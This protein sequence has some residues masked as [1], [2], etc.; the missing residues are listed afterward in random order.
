M[1][2]SA[3]DLA[4][5]AARAGFRGKDLAVAVAVALAESRGDTRAHHVTGREDSRGAWQINIK[6]WPEFATANLYDLD[7]NAKAAF[8][9]WQRKGWGPWSTHN[10][11]AWLLFW[12]VAQMAAESNVVKR[13]NSDP[14]S[15]AG[16]LA[17]VG[18]AVTGG[19]VSAAGDMLGA[20]QTAAGSLVKA[21]G[22]LGDRNNWVRVAQV[23]AGGAVL[24]GGVL[25]LVRPTGL[26]NLVPIGR[27][28]SMAKKLA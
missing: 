28:A 8:S 20:V 4:T 1:A 21:G 3:G 10:S 18:D 23:T 2:A 5:A 15:V 14:G 12:P 16:D 7:T 13:L 22:W 17:N 24:V 26:A 25:V 6:A 27:A 9:I 11:G 19:A